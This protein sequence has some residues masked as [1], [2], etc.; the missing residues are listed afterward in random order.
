MLLLLIVLLLAEEED[1]FR[2]RITGKMNIGKAL[3]ALTNGNSD[4]YATCRSIINFADMVDPNMSGGALGYFK[5]LD[6]LEIYEERIHALFVVCGRDMIKM[7]ALL[8]AYQLG[9]VDAAEINGAIDDSG[10]LN[11]GSITDAVRK[12]LPDFD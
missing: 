9:I 2:G 3:E 7:L 8:R 5:I 11:L 10:P 1:M 12:Q 6:E 4:S